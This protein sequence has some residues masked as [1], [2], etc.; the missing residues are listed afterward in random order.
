MLESLS[1]CEATDG[2]ARRSVR[3]CRGV[4]VVEC[5]AISGVVSIATEGAMAWSEEKSNSESGVQ[6]LELSKGQMR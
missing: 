3:G 1:G 2:G 6:E 5:G 4:M